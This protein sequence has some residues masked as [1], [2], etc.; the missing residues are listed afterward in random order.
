MNLSIANNSSPRGK[1]AWLKCKE[2]DA[3][4][5]PVV[6]L[7]RNKHM[8]VI[9]CNENW[10]Q[11]AMSFKY[12]TDCYIGDEGELG[13]G[14]IITAPYGEGRFEILEVRIKYHYIMLKTKGA[15]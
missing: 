7:W 14:V 3:S 11:I 12:D 10:E 9:I 1:S 13:S 6:V 4:E 5:D 2:I 15:N 8:K